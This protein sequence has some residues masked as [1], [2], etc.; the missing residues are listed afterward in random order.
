[1][2]RTLSGEQPEHRSRRGS[3]RPTSVSSVRSYDLA[4]PVR[5]RSSVR[6]PVPAEARSRPAP[7][8]QLLQR[9]GGCHLRPCARA[10]PSSAA[11]SSRCSIDPGRHAPLQD[12]AAAIGDRARDPRGGRILTLKIRSVLHRSEPWTAIG[13]PML[14]A[15]GK[16]SKSNSRWLRHIMLLTSVP[17]RL[18]QKLETARMRAARR[19]KVTVDAQPSQTVVPCT[20]RKELAALPA[21]VPQGHTA[22]PREHRRSTTGGR[23][24]RSILRKSARNGRFNTS[25]SASSTSSGFCGRSWCRRGRSAA[26]RRPARVSPASPRGST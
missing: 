12:H 25:S 10:A 20:S 1:M 4:P 17:V 22:A 11:I 15:I 3:R 2:S 9:S 24:W 8:M 18:A 7:S 21:P 23:K 5:A 6:V 26:C 14:R 16:T 13:R 19:S